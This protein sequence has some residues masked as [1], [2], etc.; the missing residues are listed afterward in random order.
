LLTPPAFTLPEP[1]G[2]WVRDRHQAVLITI[3]SDGAPQS[4]NV[5][6]AA[7]G[8]RFLVSV[9]ADRAKTV[10]LRRDPR[11]VLHVLGPAFGSYASIRVAADV[12]APSGAPGD[13]VG[14]R[15]LEVYERIT[16]AAHPDP[17]EFYRAMVDERRLLLT[18]TPVASTGWGLPSGSAVATSR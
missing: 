4:S 12:G 18:L 15:L 3:R 7:D 8:E 9:T 2:R 13:A 16:G 10:N 6:F 5:V 1:V 11:A 17:E 14:V